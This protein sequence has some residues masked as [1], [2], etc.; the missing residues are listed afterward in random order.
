MQHTREQYSTP[1]LLSRDPT[2]CIKTTFFA[3]FPFISIL[4][5]AGHSYKMWAKE[6]F[7][8]LGDKLYS[9]GYKA[10]LIGAE[11]E[12]ELLLEVAQMM[13]NK[14][15]IPLINEPKFGQDPIYSIGLFKSS[16]L[17]VGCDCGGL[18]LATLSGCPVIGIYGPTDPVKSGPLGERNIVIYKGLNC[19]P[20][21]MKDC[22]LEHR[23]LETVAPDEIVEAVNFLLRSTSGR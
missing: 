2:H 20:C 16:T 9:M 23:C 7:A 14:P 18:H 1:T 17:T 4:P 11:G 12:K 10:I 5:G 22:K 8:T 6:K 15:I 19:S 3:F 21:R 13:K